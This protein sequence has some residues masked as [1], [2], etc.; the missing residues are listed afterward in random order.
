MLDL[1]SLRITAIC[2]EMAVLMSTPAVAGSKNLVAGTWLTV[3][4]KAD[5]DGENRDLFGPHP[6]GQLIFTEGLRFAV[7]L[8]NPDIPRFASSDR[9]GGTEAEN[10]AAVS[11]DLALYG[12]YTVDEQGLFATER[13]IAS[14]VPNWTGLDR[15]TSLITETVDGDTMVERLKDPGGPQ[16]LIV[17]KRAK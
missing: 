11:G 13:I 12:T 4:A 17:W 15:D 10:Q 3:S 9:A 7:I 1:S 16:I 6:S 8:V 5:P 14:S 2:L